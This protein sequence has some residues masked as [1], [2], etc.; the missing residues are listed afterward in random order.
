MKKMLNIKLSLLTALIVFSSCEK[1]IDQQPQTSLSA[2]TAYT[3]RQGIEAG[4]LGCYNA[5]QST[6]YYGLEFW[7][8]SDMYAGVITHTGTFPTYAQ[9]NNK[10][11]L[12]DNTNVTNMWNAIYGGINRV[13]TIIA[14]ADKL[15]DP[16]FN[17]MQTVGEARFLR[18]LMHFDLLRAFGGSATGFNKADG[19]GIPVR[20]T[21]TLSPEDASAIALTPEADVWKLIDGDLDYAIANL[22]ATTSGRATVNAAKAL[23]ARAA[24]YKEDWATAETLSTEVIN[25]LKG[26]GTGLASDFGAL[27]ATQNT[28]PESIFELQYDINNTNS[29]A[30][31][32]FPTGLGGRNE[33]GSST[34]LNAQSATDLRK[35]TNVKVLSGSN[36]TGKYS[37]INGTD[38][39]III[40]LAELYLNRAEARAK[41]AAPDLTGALSD[42]NVIRAR[43]GLAASTAATAADIL[44]QVYEDRYYEFAHEGHAFF[45][46]KRTNRLASTFTGFSGANAFR[47]IYPTPQREII[48]SAGQIT[49]VAGY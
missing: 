32:Y 48:N 34:T 8:L 12:P 11:L 27:W 42:L 47:A 49:Q 10:Q 38:N 46:Y 31:Y 17:K 20:V 22:S 13:N 41:K 28:K 15:N 3:T 5:L 43:A 24:L 4:L 14:S 26:T 7:A 25:A 9:F 2:E 45:D 23:K 33:I 40:R 19:R 35:A 6:S 1:I 16:A 36:K 21:P 44:K 39:V 29:I 37:R 30:F 18:A